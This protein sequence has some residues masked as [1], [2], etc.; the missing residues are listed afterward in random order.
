V[1][2]GETN[3][4]RILT[5]DGCVNVRDLGGLGTGD[6][7]MVRWGALVRSDLLSQ[8]T[9]IGR[10]A[11]LLHGIRTIVD[12][13]YVDEVARDWQEYPFR[14]WQTSTALGGLRYVNVPFDTGRPSAEDPGR[15]ADYERATTRGELNCLDLDW[16]QPGI[17]AIV[18]AIADATPGGVLVHCAGGK[19]RT[20]LSI[21]LVLSLLGVADETIAN[22]YA[23]SGLTLEPRL[24]E[25]LDSKSQDEA[26]RDRLRRLVLPTREA[27]FETLGHLYSRYGSGEAYLRGGGVTDAQMDRLRTRLLR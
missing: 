23:M 20:G 17:G 2:A 22:D 18:G 13:R 21:A 6:G 5:W 19:D 16:N 10:H 3:G 1:I 15:Q 4:H 12:V 9:E 14:D 25:W 26:Q 27:M 24:S 8:L 7:Q 11:P